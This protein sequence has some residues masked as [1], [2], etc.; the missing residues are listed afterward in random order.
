MLISSVDSL[1]VT[2]RNSVL[3]TV[4]VSFS[5]L[6]STYKIT[7]EIHPL[8]TWPPN[9]DSKVIIPYNYPVYT[10]NTVI[11]SPEEEVKFLCDIYSSPD[12][13]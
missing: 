9:K 11:P 13:T 7:S 4:W 1:T 3:P 8:S 12:I 5:P 2:L 10:E 6:K